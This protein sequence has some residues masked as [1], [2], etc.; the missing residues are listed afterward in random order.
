MGVV[1]KRRELPVFQYEYAG[2]RE[3][4]AGE[5]GVN[6]FLVPLEVEGG[7][8]QNQVP[9]AWATLH[10]GYGL[11]CYWSDGIRGQCRGCFMNKPYAISGAVHRSDAGTSG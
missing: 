8:C 4:L 9:L 7:V 5:N 1:H 3:P 10:V 11:R 6:Q 2:F